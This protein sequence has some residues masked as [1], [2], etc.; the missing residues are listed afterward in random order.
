MGWGYVGKERAETRRRG[1]G[2][3]PKSS[4][5]KSQP[6]P[7]LQRRSTSTATS[8]PACARLQS[9]LR[10]LGDDLF[11][12]GS[13]TPRT[14][15]LLRVADGRSQSPRPAMSLPHP[16]PSA[17][18]RLPRPSPFLPSRAASLP[19]T[20]RTACCAVPGLPVPSVSVSR[21]SPILTASFIPWPSCLSGCSRSC[22]VLSRLVSSA[23]PPNGSQPSLSLAHR[24]MVTRA[25]WV[26]GVWATV[27]VCVCVCRSPPCHGQRKII[28]SLARHCPVTSLNMSRVSRQS[29][30]PARCSFPRHF[31]GTLSARL[32]MDRTEPA[33]DRRRFRLKSSSPAT[34]IFD[35]SRSQADLGTSPP[36]HIPGYFNESS[37]ISVL[38]YVVH[39][40]C[41][42]SH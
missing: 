39:A 3:T 19:P 38:E 34:V 25:S 28:H 1:N 42:V 37:H 27:C 14:P 32:S 11:L 36:R 8:A 21:L 41:L 40:A 6:R 26:D 31:S 16:L 10:P 23:H 7:E 2:Q 22:L 4:S 24:R 5:V 20:H 33:S 15:V 29:A 35:H 13:P 18:C 9:V 17:P 12:T 30:P